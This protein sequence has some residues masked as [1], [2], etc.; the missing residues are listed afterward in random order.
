MELNTHACI[1]IQNIKSVNVTQGKMKVAPLFT[2]PTQLAYFVQP[3]LFPNLLSS[4]LNSVE[5][6]FLSK[7]I[8]FPT[9]TAL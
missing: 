8:Y 3:H 5:G 4:H 7:S 9:F 6:R 2:L 1:C